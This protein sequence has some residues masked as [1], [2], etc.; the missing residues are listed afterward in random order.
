MLSIWM[1]LCDRVGIHEVLIN[2]HAHA[3]V[4]CEFLRNHS[5][6]TRIRVAVEPQLLG[7]AGTLRA[8]RGWVKSDELFWIFYADVL[9]NADLTGMLRN[10]Q[11]KKPAATIG[12]YHVP[13]PHRCGI[14]TVDEQDMVQ[15]FVE[16]PRVPMGNLAFSGLMIGTAEMLDAIPAAI[17]SDIGFDVLPQLV[18]RMLAYPIHDYLIDIGTMANYQAAQNTWPGL[19]GVR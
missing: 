8:N 7:S 2:L 6:G 9:N 19:Q 13:E 10:H 1:D 5:H 12:V 11:L 18:G 3:D 4:V 17:P 14:V 15:Q 16:K